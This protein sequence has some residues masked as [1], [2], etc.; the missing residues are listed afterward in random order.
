MKAADQFDCNRFLAIRL[1]GSAPTFGDT[2]RIGS[3]LQSL[4]N[5]L[6]AQLAEAKDHLSIENAVSKSEALFRFAQKIAL[7]A[8]IRHW[9]LRV[10]GGGFNFKL[11]D[12]TRLNG[13]GLRIQFQR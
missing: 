13:N 6:I 11:G 8:D 1:L 7:V 2:C 9:C 4:F 5:E 12:V 10:G 3:P